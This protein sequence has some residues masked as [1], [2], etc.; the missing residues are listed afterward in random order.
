MAGRT[1]ASAAA[2]SEGGSTG[3]APPGRPVL[4]IEDLRV[5]F[6]SLRGVVKA[7]NGVNLTVHEREIVGLV[8][9][10]GCGKTVTG[11]SVLGLLP[12]PQAQVTGGRILFNGEDLVEKSARELRTL[13][14]KVISMVFQDPLAS[15][16][17][18]LSVGEQISRVIRAHK[19]VKKKEAL[20]AAR[21]A[22]VATDLPGTDS[23]LKSY[24]HQLSGG[25]RQRVCMAMAIS[26][27]SALL[28]ADEPTTALDVTIQMQILTLLLELRERLGVAQVLITHNVGVAAR[29]CDR[30]AVMYAGNVVEDGPTAEVLKRPRHPYTV[31]LIECLPQGKKADQLQ[32][33]PGTV[34][35]LIAPP[36][37]CRFHERCWRVLDVCRDVL[38]TPIEVARDHWTACHWVQRE[39]AGE[40]RSDARSER[41][42][43]GEG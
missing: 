22:I 40:R 15:L 32:T 29:T 36:P 21:T 26:C 7:L 8:G 18:V 10:S 14:G 30:I 41:A 4:E 12:K 20:E 24:P 33:I 42:G 5:E 39:I 9:E 13:T 23:L 19:D 3:A 35:D 2:A 38:P 1:T 27:G 28:I 25:M 16:N 17:P 43:E 31:A 6:R 37:G 34:P 11:Y